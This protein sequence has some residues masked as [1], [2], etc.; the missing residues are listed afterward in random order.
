MLRFLPCAAGI[1]SFAENIGSIQMFL[2][3]VGLILLFA[4]MF[5]PGF[6]IAGISGSVCII[7][8]IIMTARTAL[9]AFVM[10]MIFLLVLAFV[11]FIILR[12]A[13]KGRLSKTLVLKSTLKKEDG[14]SSVDEYSALTG[15]E[16]IA[17][18]QLR[19]SGTGEFEGERYDVV[20]EGQFIQAGTAI[21]VVHI[22]GRRIVVRPIK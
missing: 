2:F 22:E 10:L 18:T 21:V 19:P 15:K 14:Y 12:S 17:L 6:G 1:F 9:E 4:E 3:V 5:M 20:T 16:G 13:K 7:I 8:G 11:L